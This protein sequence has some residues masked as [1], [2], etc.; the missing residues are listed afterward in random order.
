MYSLVPRVRRRQLKQLTLDAWKETDGDM[1]A[2]YE[3][4]RKK[5]E[6]C[7]SVMFW[8]TLIAVLMQI[9]YYA[10]K[11]LEERKVEADEEHPTGLKLTRSI[12]EELNK[13]FGL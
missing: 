4:T 2:T 10:I 5:V 9:V 3:L 8:L 6:A 13:A 7:G 12:D 1:E 11:I